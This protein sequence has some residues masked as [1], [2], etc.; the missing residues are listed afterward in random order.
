MFTEKEHKEMTSNVL[1]SAY[2]KKM[3]A[4]FEKALAIWLDGVEDIDLTNEDSSLKLLMKAMI[5]ASDEFED[6]PNFLS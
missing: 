3:L 2:A 4:S 6:E 1:E 5:E